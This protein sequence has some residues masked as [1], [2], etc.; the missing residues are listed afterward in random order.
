MRGRS[1]TWI[2]IDRKG[3]KL[4]NDIFDLAEM[5][6]LIGSTADTKS[7]RKAVKPTIG[8]SASARI[9]ARPD[10]QVYMGVLAAMVGC[11]PVLDEVQRTLQ[12]EKESTGGHIVFNVIKRRW[13][14]RMV[15]A[16]DVYEKVAAVIP[17]GEFTGA[18]ITDA[19]IFLNT[20]WTG[21]D[22]DALLPAMTWLWG[23]LSFFAFQSKDWR[24]GEGFRFLYPGVK[25]VGWE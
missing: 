13:P 1:S 3:R 5:L 7:L 19:R 8:R 22:E 11:S 9:D 17:R 16:E 14:D 23:K 2:E 18:A 10:C 21:I 12:C 4:E 25:P 24:E 20:C 6:A 15:I